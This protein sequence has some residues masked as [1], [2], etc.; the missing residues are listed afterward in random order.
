MLKANDLVGEF[1]SV[2]VYNFNL[3]VDYGSRNRTV[4]CESLVLVHCTI[5]H[6]PYSSLVRPTGS[7][8]RVKSPPVVP[9]DA[10]NPRIRHSKGRVRGSSCPVGSCAKDLAARTVCQGRSSRSKRWVA[11]SAPPARHMW[12]IDLEEP[13]ATASSKGRPRCSM[14]ELKPKCSGRPQR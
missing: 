9:L 11:K 12:T 2:R 10:A 7:R 4:S 5:H 8:A 13:S 14:S 3:L 6:A 1:E